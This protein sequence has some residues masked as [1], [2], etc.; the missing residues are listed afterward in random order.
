MAL[1]SRADRAATRKSHDRA[2][3]SPVWMANP[4]IAATVSLSRSRTAVLTAWEMT[5]SPL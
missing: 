2:N 3:D 1:P 5:R 4:L